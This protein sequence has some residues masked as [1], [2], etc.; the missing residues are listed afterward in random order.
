MYIG[1]YMNG[2][3]DSWAVLALNMIRKVGPVPP[4]FWAPG[5]GS[6]GERFFHRLGLGAR[7]GMLPA[8]RGWG[9]ACL[10]GLLSGMLWLSTS[11]QTGVWGPLIYTY[12]GSELAP[13]LLSLS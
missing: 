11:P 4:I 8:S 12:Y 13:L 5:I 6:N 7:F 9:I 2:Y 1:R 3:I 10:C